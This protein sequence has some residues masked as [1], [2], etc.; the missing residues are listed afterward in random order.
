MINLNE[1]QPETSQM[2]RTLIPLGTVARAIILVKMGDVT[3]PEFGNGQWFKKSQSSAAKWMELEFT[4]VGGQFDRRKFWDR[5]FVDGDKL[6]E[7]GIP[8]AKEIGLRT[9]RSI[10]ESANSLDPSDMSPEAQSRRQ[11]SG[12]DALNG[13]EICAKVGVKKGTNGYEDANKLMVALTPNQ[14]EFISSG[15]NAT[16]Q[17]QQP[18]YQPQAPAPTQPAS[19]GPIPSWANK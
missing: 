2:E 14:K 12:V 7:S 15:N 6:G 9:L 3:I 8:L 13:M 16:Q 10:I 1:V 17:V 5:I 19:S 11:I 4:I 18:S